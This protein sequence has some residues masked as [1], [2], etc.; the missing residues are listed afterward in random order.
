MAAYRATPHSSTGFSPN[1]LFTGRETIAPI[2]LVLSDSLVADPVGQ[3]VDTFVQRT[4]GRMQETYLLARS[5]LQRNA[6]FRSARYNLRVKPATFPVGQWVWYHC[7]R[8]SVGL[9]DKWT[10]YYDGPYKVLDQVGPVLYRIQKSARAHPKIVY[11]DK[12]KLFDGDTPKDW[13]SSTAPVEIADEEPLGLEA[14]EVEDREIPVSRP[15]RP[16]ILPA[17]FRD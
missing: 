12:L 5:H 2:D 11:V 6:D 1:L 16:R 3:D 13:D 9:K 8:R 4:L 17:R 10:K 7:P 14:L 15:T